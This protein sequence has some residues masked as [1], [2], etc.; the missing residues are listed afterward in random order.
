MTHLLLALCLL[1]AL[2]PGQTANATGV[3]EPAEVERLMP[4]QVFFR[5]QSATVQIR[6]SAAF[7]YKDGTV[8]LAGVVD[9]GGYSTAQRETYQFYLLT[10]VAL[11]VGGKRIAP[12]AY[13]CGF[14]PD[15]GFL[16]MDLG[17]NELLHVPTTRD[18]AMARPRPLLMMPGNGTDDF[19]LYVGREYIALQRAR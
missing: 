12:G 16:V 10:D 8:T 17:G 19:K 11:E 14:L 3:L 2:A 9:T 1:P 4:S 18:P 15:K 6:N 5:S 13:G 7:R